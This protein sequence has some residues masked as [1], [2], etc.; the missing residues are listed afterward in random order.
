MTSFFLWLN[1]SK[2]SGLKFF[3]SQYVLSWAYGI[4]LFVM[5]EIQCHLRDK[6]A[7]LT[8]VGS[9]AI[10][11]AHVQNFATQF[12]PRSFCFLYFGLRK[13]EIFFRPPEDCP[14]VPLPDDDIKDPNEKLTRKRN[15]KDDLHHHDVNT[16]SRPKR[17]RLQNPKEQKQNMLSENEED[18]EKDAL[19][20]TKDDSCVI[21]EETDLGDDESSQDGECNRGGLPEETVWHHTRS[22]G[23]HPLELFEKPNM[24]VTPRSSK[25]NRSFLDA[26]EHSNS[27]DRLS[28]SKS[29]RWK[30]KDVGELESILQNILAE[31]K[32]SVVGMCERVFTNAV[33]AVTQLKDDVVIKLQAAKEEQQRRFDDKLQ[34]EKKDIEKRFQDVCKDYRRGLKTKIDKEVRQINILEGK[35]KK[36]VDAKNTSFQATASAI[37]DELSAKLQE[38][39]SNSLTAFCMAQSMHVQRKLQLFTE[40]LFE[41]QTK[42]EIDLENEKLKRLTEIREEF[43]KAVNRETILQ[44]CEKQVRHEINTKLI[45]EVKATAQETHRTVQEKVDQSQVHL[46]KVYEH[47][48]FNKLTKDNPLESVKSILE[49]V[50]SF[51]VK[52]NK[53][54]ENKKKEL[55][56]KTD[57]DI[58]ASKEELLNQFNSQKATASAFHALQMDEEKQNLEE[59]LCKT[60]D[61]IQQREANVKKY[62][63]FLEGASNRKPVERV[64]TV[65]E[66]KTKQHL[67]ET[68]AASSEQE[69]CESS[70]LESSHVENITDWQPSCS[71]RVNEVHQ[72]GSA[73]NK[74]EQ[75]HPLEVRQQEEQGPSSDKKDLLESLQLQERSFQRE[76][77]QIDGIDQTPLPETDKGDLFQP[78][79]EEKTVQTSPLKNDITSEMQGC[80]VKAQEKEV[81]SSRM[82]EKEVNTEELMESLEQ[83]HCPDVPCEEA[84]TLWKL[85]A[86]NQVILD[87]CNPRN[88]KY[89]EKTHNIE[90]SPALVQQA[91][92]DGKCRDGKT[93]SS[94]HRGAPHVCQTKD[95]GNMDGLVVSAKED[96]EQSSPTP[97]SSPEQSK[98]AISYPDAALTTKAAVVNNH[99]QESKEEEHRENFEE[100]RGFPFVNDHAETLVGSTQMQEPKTSLKCH[101]GKR[102]PQN[103]EE[104]THP[105]E[106][107]SVPVM[108][109]KHREKPNPESTTSLKETGRISVMKDHPSL[110]SQPCGN[111]FCQEVLCKEET[112]PPV[113]HDKQFRCGHGA[114]EDTSEDSESPSRMNLQV[115]HQACEQGNAASFDR[116]CGRVV[117]SA[118]FCTESHPE[119]SLQDSTGD[120]NETQSNSSLSHV[121][122]HHFLQKDHAKDGKT[123]SNE[124]NKYL[125]TV[126]DSLLCKPDCEASQSKLQEKGIHMKT[127]QDI[128]PADVQFDK[129]ANSK[130]T[131]KQFVSEPVEAVN[132]KRY[133]QKQDANQAEVVSEDMETKGIMQQN[134]ILSEH[135]EAEDACRRTKTENPD[136]VNEPNGFNEPKSGVEEPDEPDSSL[137]ED[138][139]D[140]ALDQDGSDSSLDQHGSDSGLGQ[141]ESVTDDDYAPLAG[142]H[143]SNFGDNDSFHSE[144]ADSHKA[145][146]EDALSQ[147]VQAEV[148]D[149]QKVHTEDAASQKVHPRDAHSQKEAQDGDSEKVHTEDNASKKDTQDGCSQKVYAE[150]ENS[151]KVDAE[152][153]DSQKAPPEHGDSQKVPTEDG[154][155]QKVHAEDAG[156]QKVQPKDV[157]SQQKHSQ[158]ALPKDAD[159]QQN[160]SQKVHTEDAPSQKVHPKDADSQQKDSKKAHTE[161]AY[162]QQ[163]D[164]QKVNTEDGD[165][166]KVHTEVADSQTVCTQD[167]DSQKVHA[168]MAD[169]QSEDAVQSQ[170]ESDPD[171]EIDVV[172]LSQEV[173]SDSIQATPVNTDVR[174]DNNF[175]SPQDEEMLASEEVRK[176]LLSDWDP[177]E[178]TTKR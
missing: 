35:L 142:C 110:Q 39:H 116:I 175:L 2:T 125:P 12:F 160:D 147:N 104:S 27:A 153:A 118:T 67:T 128:P 15:L 33:S 154:D 149:S 146:T 136:N 34:E 40:E 37:K 167:S 1:M 131:L 60:R 121:N 51:E 45:N 80:T 63:Y 89:T 134:V 119:G 52:L 74:D 24:L 58:S 9:S 86:V 82:Q 145:H 122:G 64:N 174:A 178:D 115:P 36:M 97:I 77:P 19:N 53:D 113:N 176:Q 18:E 54:T 96:L 22:K 92:S 169:S 83:N 26:F 16:P 72:A 168:E 100:V 7:D 38:A 56:Q 61:M 108:M 31:N 11:H 151:Q 105:E 62:S 162:S 41:S 129:T 157:D 158:M 133:D 78:G 87:T 159:S 132:N 90:S 177:E 138:E 21:Q 140:S 164:P 46:D 17:Q 23:R 48:N 98:R 91:D 130:Q 14:H 32:E 120:A 107:E 124:E 66:L 71:G 85:P 25:T 155:T 148:A 156:S 123:Q 112:D 141:D 114:V 163:N 3:R 94:E 126:M 173:K 111:S 59:R 68:F 57:D 43:Q 101:N 10:F 143:S 13:V 65:L 8:A 93:N 137:D 88:D 75:D 44:D 47:I 49:N 84:Q 50:R 5:F 70:G 117:G 6:N 76:K 150:I 69:E 109:N 73:V 29:S 81:P 20:D 99:Q 127:T 42:Y 152:H 135:G 103:N 161:D 28:E 95:A 144:D 171:S 30:A 55:I 170:P 102:F 139:P 166:H 4:A 79:K 172:T 106:N 165:S